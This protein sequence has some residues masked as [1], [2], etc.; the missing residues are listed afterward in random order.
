MAYTPPSNVLIT[1][2]DESAETRI[3]EAIGLA[4]M[5]IS[6]FW[7]ETVLNQQG[8]ESL[9]SGVA[10]KNWYINRLYRLGQAGAVEMDPNDTFL[11]GESNTEF[12]AFGRRSKFNPITID[13]RVVPKSRHVLMTVPMRSQRAMLVKTVGEAIYGTNPAMQGDIEAGLMMDFGHTIARKQCGYWYT[14]Q[15]DSYQLC[16]VSSGAWVNRTSDVVGDETFQFQTSNEA[17]ERFNE[18]Q[19]IEFRYATDPDGSG[20]LEAGDLINDSHV[21][22]VIAVDPSSNT[23]EVQFINVTGT[24]APG[25][26]Y[27]IPDGARVIPWRS[28]DH[29]G[30]TITGI[31]GINSYLRSDGD[32]LGDDAVGTS[33]EGKITGEDHPQFRSI[34]QAINGSLTLEVLRRWTALAQRQSSRLNMAGIDT[35]FTTEGVLRNAVNEMQ[36]YELNTNTGP[37]GGSIVADGNTGYT[38]NYNGKTFRIIA[39]PWCDAGTLYGTQLGGNNWKRA[40]PEDLTGFASA[41]SI[42]TQI[43][44]RFIANWYGF[45]NNQFPIYHVD[46]SGST[47]YNQLTEG[48]QLPGVVRYQ[49]VPDNPVGLKLTG[50]TEDNVFQDAVATTS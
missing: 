13:P 1:D 44:F 17:I 41:P 37:V 38:F 8:V 6:P 25:S 42:P 32:L 40:V 33:G 45:Q 31:A 43:P 29:S 50:L 15:N 34:E 24:V 23:V 30:N 12:G 4:M 11:F 49:V 28:G 16:T 2:F 14:S 35:M 9:T 36:A 7:R 18:N 26:T 20:S 39:D 10:S 3:S 19:M 5:A 27:V 46:T 21:G 48:V 47:G 22:Y